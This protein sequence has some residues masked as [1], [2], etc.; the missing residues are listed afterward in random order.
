VIGHPDCRA[1]LVI[2]NVVVT[3]KIPFSQNWIKSLD[4]SPQ[5]HVRA[6]NDCSTRACKEAPKA[7]FDRMGVQ[8]EYED[9]HALSPFVQ[10]R[11]GVQPYVDRLLA[12][13]ALVLVYPVWNEG[14][15]AILKGFLDRVFLPGVSFE[16]APNR[17]I[18]PTLRN[19]KNWRPFACTG[20]PD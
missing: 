13:D 17:S 9:A 10:T 7:R 3:C 16:V 14:F 5:H 2:R 1:F 19:I 20:P 11:L 8:H 15:P 6:R 12:A 18:T 4:V